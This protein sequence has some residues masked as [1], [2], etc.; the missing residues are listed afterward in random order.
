MSQ[1]VRISL[2]LMGSDKGPGVLI[3][4]AAAARSEHP[5]IRYVI[6]GRE[7]EVVPLL[8]RYP[9]V[10][11]CS[12]FHHTD[13]VV[14]MEDKPSQ[15]LR[16]GRW[17]S[18]MWRAI[19]AVKKREVDVAVSAGNTGALMAMSTFC[20]RPMEGIE[21]PALAV[22]WPN[23]RGASVALDVGSTPG[24][25]AKR[26]GD[27]CMMGATMARIVFDIDKPVVGLLNASIDEIRKPLR[28]ADATLRESNR[29]NLYQY[30]GFIGGDD[31]SSGSV[32]VIVMDGFTGNVALK[33][34]EGTAKQVF[35]YLRS[36]MSDTL[37][38]RIGFFFARSAFAEL[39]SKA[40]PRKFDGGVF[41]GL[42]GLVVKSHGGADEVSFASAIKV[43]YDAARYNLLDSIA[44]SSGSVELQTLPARGSTRA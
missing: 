34:A 8:E 15:A 41:L 35:A 4:G 28:D 14:R 10:R 27:L 9:S 38:G 36:A 5:D 21:R 32:D 44:G 2:D 16:A 39:R 42:N 7:S 1:N 22:M 37:L 40:D 11:D 19:E 20:L 31:I 18:S 25:D 3:S 13:V 17:K 24:A 12:T 29:A 43:A 33:T 30:A 26:L 6:Y 23:A